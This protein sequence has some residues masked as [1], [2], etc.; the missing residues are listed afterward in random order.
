MTKSLLCLSVFLISTAQCAGF[1]TRSLKTDNDDS[2][3]PSINSTFMPILIDIMI[4]GKIVPLVRH[5]GHYVLPQSVM[6]KEYVLRLQNITPYRQ[7]AIVSIDGISI[8]GVKPA[9]RNSTGYVL[10]PWQ[11]AY[12][13]GWRKDNRS[14]NAFKFLPVERSVATALGTRSQ[15]G[16]IRITAVRELKYQDFQGINNGVRSFAKGGTGSGRRINDRSRYVSF[17]R[18]NIVYSNL[19]RYS[20]KPKPSKTSER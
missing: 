5:S 12:I 1:E 13:R 17:R 2:K 9:N 8:V 6:G 18:S 3:N 15:I 4:D 16:Q 14:V 19:L 11:V 20:F 10:N 7:L